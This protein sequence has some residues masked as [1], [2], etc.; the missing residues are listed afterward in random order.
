MKILTKFFSN[1]YYRD[2]FVSG[3][4]YFSSLTEYTRVKSE[5][6]LKSLA[7]K[8][9][10][11]AQEELD[12]IRN[13]EH[14]DVSEGT[15]AT[16]PKNFCIDTDVPLIPNDFAEYSLCDERIRA[17]GYDFCNVQCFCML[18]CK[19]EIGECGCQRGLDIPDMDAFGQHAVI[20]LNPEKFV[21][22]VIEAVEKSGYDVLTGPI[23]YHS[24]KNG[25]RS[26]VGGRF[27]HIQREDSVFFGDALNIM[28]DEQKYD[29]FDK[30]ERYSNQRE[31][32]IVVNKHVAEDKPIRLE[33][34]D[35]SDNVTKCDAKEFD[36]RII[37]LLKKHRFRNEVKGFKGN[38]NRERMRDDFYALGNK[39]GYIL[40]TMGNVEYGEIKKEAEF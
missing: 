12:K 6:Y 9:C 3:S 36:E 29:A 7:D 38:I 24:L 40:S 34:G 39:E 8:G 21:S 1:K 27:L 26:I 18:N 31:W 25:D 32:R 28:S 4:L 11:E 23:S 35:L 2:Q 17:K 20:I 14:R 16:V 37:K 5:R 15:I 22:K 33:V 10:I 13:S 30:W 19:Y